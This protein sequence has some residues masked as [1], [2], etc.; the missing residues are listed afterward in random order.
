MAEIHLDA[1]Q[2]GH[3]H[4]QTLLKNIRQ[5]DE[6][7]IFIHGG[8]ALSPGILSTV[9]KG[10]HMISILNDLSPDLMAVSK[11]D[12]AH[13]EDALSLRCFEAAFPIVCSNIFDPLTEGPLE[14]LLT[15]FI[16]NVGN[17]KVGFIS[18]IDPEVIA[19]YMPQRITTTDL[20]R[21]VIENS[22]LLR[23]QGADLVILVAGF[24]IE[25][26]NS[27]LSSPPVDV[28]LLSETSA[29]I[30]LTQQGNSLFELKGHKGIASIIT[31]KIT[32]NDAGT[33]WTG[34]GKTVLLNNYAPDPIVEE[35]IDAYLIQLSVLLDKVIG[36]TRTN[37]DTR[38][39][40]IRKGENA[41][42]NLTA[43]AIRMYYQSDVALINA[44]GFRGNRQYPSGS[45]LTVGDIQKELPFNNRVI[46]L[47]LSG[48]LLQHAI[49]KGLSRIE[50]MKGCFP[51]I[52]GIIVKYD[53]QKPP[54]QRIVSITI[55]GEP[56]DLFKTYNL[57]TTDYLANG[58]DGYTDLTGAERIVK[59]GETRLLW[60]YVRDYIAEKAAISPKI[61]G[62]MT[63]V[64]HNKL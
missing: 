53:P 28:V 55:N 18:V 35:K 54:L 1:D 46:N 5:I 14:G 63:A 10:A 42:A 6:Q 41:L 12:L 26:F 21:A 25:S 19:D 52:S 49:E 56:L 44:G 59:V 61:D 31:L 8:D 9:D 45:N 64:T 32:K 30:G 11:S 36:M 62:R 39:E 24:N 48:K 16:Q 20:N 43:D 13:Q 58:G 51:H 34:D 15:N 22:K 4:L 40:S 37:L 27:Y 2:G 23:Q 7:V 29:N 57:T 38:R 47:K 60:E 33:Q 17:L 3:A 50:E